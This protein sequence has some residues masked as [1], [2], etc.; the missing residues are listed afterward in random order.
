MIRDYSL[1]D[2]RR[3]ESELLSDDTDRVHPNYSEN[4][5]Y[6]WNFIH[7]KSHFPHG[8]LLGPNSSVRYEKEAAN[9]LSHY[10]GPKE[11]KFARSENVHIY[12]PSVRWEE[13]INI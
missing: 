11:L 5:L 2:R 13:K 10:T 3:K 8:N 1:G 12:C 7:H 6:Q 4:V 9:N